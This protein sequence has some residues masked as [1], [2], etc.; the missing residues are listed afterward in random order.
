MGIVLELVLGIDPSVDLDVAR[1]AAGRERSCL[2]H[3]DLGRGGEQPADAVAGAER[4]QD[5]DARGERD[6]AGDQRDEG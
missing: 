6:E 2:G 5:E 3:A 4:L 1:P